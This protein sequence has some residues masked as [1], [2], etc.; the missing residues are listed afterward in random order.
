MASVRGTLLDDPDVQIIVSG[1]S[2][3]C[4]CVCVCVF[5]SHLLLLQGNDI[6]LVARQPWT[7]RQ[8]GNRESRRFEVVFREVSGSEHVNRK[9]CQE[10]HRTRLTAAVDSFFFL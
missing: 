1:F 4:V 7:V 9:C 5:V 10:A 2:T 6:T 3:S 8:Q